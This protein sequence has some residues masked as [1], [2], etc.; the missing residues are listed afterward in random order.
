MSKHT[1]KLGFEGRHQRV[2]VTTPDGEPRPWDADSALRVVGKPTPRIDG[3]AK[4][5]GAARYTVDARPEGLVHAAILRCP[6]PCAILKSLDLSRAEKLP[7]VV[8]VMP[9]ATVGQRL[10]F[11]GQ[12]VAA[13]AARTRGEAQ[14]AIAAI[15]A[16]FQPQAFTVDTREAM[17]DGAP[18]VHTTAVQERRTEG[19]EPGAGGSA[20]GARGNVRPTPSMKRGDAAKGLR[21]ADVT[22]EAEYD[23]QVHTHSA[24]EPHCIVVRWDGDDAMTVWCST[25]AIGSVRSEMADLFGLKEDRVEVIAEYVGGGFGAKFGANAPGSA[26]GKIA[27]ELARKA[28][29]PV[30][31]I[32]DR[33]E[34]HLCTGNRPDSIQRVKLGATKDG[35]LTA[36]HVL[37]FGSA[38]IATGAGVGRNAFG[39]FGKCPHVLVE[40]SD[41]FTNAGPGTAFRAPGH[42]QGAFAIESAIDEL[43]RAQ[44]WDPIAFRLAHDNHPVRR[45]Q[46]ELGRDR[47]KWGE[48]RARAAEGRAAGTRLR[49]GV[50]VASSIW[51]D[52][53][54]P[55]ARVTCVVARDGS[56]EVR[57]GIQD[58]GGG[59][60]TGM[61]MVTAEVLGVPLD[62]VRVAWGDSKFGPGTGSGG[63]KTTSTILPAT[64]NAAE[65]ART[66]LAA[67]AA[68]ALDAPKLERVTFGPDGGATYLKRSLTWSE[69]CGRLDADV[70]TVGTRP[71]TYSSHPMAFMGGD[72]HQIAGVQ[73][74][75]VEVDTWTGLVRCTKVTAIHDCG[76]VVNE[77]TLRSQ[78]NGGIIL[79]TGYA[80]FEERVM[81]RDLGVMLN[82]NLET[83]KPLGARDVPE[84]DVVLTPVETGANSTNSIGIGEP[85]TIPTAA[86]IANAVGD[87]LGVHVRSLPIRPAKVLAALE[88]VPAVAAAGGVR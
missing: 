64:R 85:A 81:D 31:V 14:A 8:A 28:K 83:Y 53:G 38:G 47:V 29:A 33:R 11:A 6:L 84:I 74:A 57:C 1:L 32:L 2:T 63:S 36:I 70:V 27:G 65:L 13:V 9:I 69:L 7:G 10:L 43:C 19:D 55:G 50:G 34:E 51:G 35:A 49:R 12:D 22:F 60:V 79:G 66:E 26:I 76:R 24:M 5:T 52:F 15:V 25:Q 59:I 72:V 17:A 67:I 20:S 61:A 30:A 58:I 3:A 86:A 44:G 21:M 82:A 40:S 56:V 45:M 71:T 18:V 41:V 4:V 87:A 80:L 68:K 78:I 75:E 48:L 88:Q 16:D 42:P 54:G 46:L 23:T 73:F 39:I 62:R 37:A 77:L